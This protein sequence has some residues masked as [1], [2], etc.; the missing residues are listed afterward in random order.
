MYVYI[1]IHLYNNNN[2]IYIFIES[3]ILIADTNGYLNKS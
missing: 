3:R 1:Y 2:T